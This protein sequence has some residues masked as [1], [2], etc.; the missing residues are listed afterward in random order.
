MKT[1][2]TLSNTKNQ[3]CLVNWTY[4][5]KDYNPSFPID[6]YGF[7]Y[8][9]EF[10]YDGESF[11]YIG[12][13]SFWKQKTLPPLKGYVRKRRSMVESDWRTYC[14]SSKEIPKTAELKSRTILEFANSK[15]HLT[16][17]EVKHMMDNDVLLDSTYYNKNILGKFFDNVDRRAGEWVKWYEKGIE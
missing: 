10:E 12:K 13:K 7:I 8:E 4:D 1:Q 14:G 16:Y 6:S 5:G 9:I 11:Y 2:K 17:L 3:T 15:V